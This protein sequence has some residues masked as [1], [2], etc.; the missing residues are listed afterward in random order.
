MRLAKS[1][2]EQQLFAGGVEEI[3]TVYFLALAADYDGTI[4]HDGTV[5]D[6]TVAALER[7]KETGL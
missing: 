6:A 1:L 2:N 7:F 5:D 4:A 3:A